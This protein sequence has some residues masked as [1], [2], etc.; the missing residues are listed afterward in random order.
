ML[1]K[2]RKQNLRLF[3]FSPSS[4][5]SKAKWLTIKQKNTFQ[6]VFILIIFSYL[7]ILIFIAYA[8]LLI[9]AYPILNRGL[10]IPFFLGKKLL[11]DY[12]LLFIC[13]LY[14][15]TGFQF[16]YL[17]MTVR[18]EV[19]SNGD[20]GSSISYYLLQSM[21]SYCICITQTGE[22]DYLV[23]YVSSSSFVTSLYI[24]QYED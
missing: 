17:S 1:N 11:I 5:M 19:G 13:R 9:I 20:C 16:R 10:I 21:V 7:N 24:K 2:N 6:F 4:E 3:N 14:I 23:C 15:F 8:A 12:C 22:R 18:A